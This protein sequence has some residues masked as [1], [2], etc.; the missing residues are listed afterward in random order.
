MT[1]SPSSQFEPDR[2]RIVVLGSTGSIGTNC[3]DVAA[4]LGSRL[5]VVGLSAHTSWELLFEQAKR[6]RPRWVT[7]TDPDKASRG[8][9]GALDGRTEVLRGEDGIL[10]MVS[11]PAVDVVVTAARA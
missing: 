1:A 11:D 8:N 9:W 2:R 10:R 3:L 4:H 6:W 5:E 7:I